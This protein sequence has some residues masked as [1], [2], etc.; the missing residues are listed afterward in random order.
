LTLPFV[1]ERHQNPSDPFEIH[2]REILYPNCDSPLPC[3]VAAILKRQWQLEGA[4]R[5]MYLLYKFRAQQQ[6]FNK[7]LRIDQSHNCAAVGIETG[8]LMRCYIAIHKL[9]FR[10]QIGI[11]SFFKPYPT[12]SHWRS[13]PSGIGSPISWAGTRPK[14]TFPR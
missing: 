3:Q 14:Y 1:A 6:L 11:I 13:S 8:F 7:S 4:G 5:F 12:A 2:Q 9:G 10:F